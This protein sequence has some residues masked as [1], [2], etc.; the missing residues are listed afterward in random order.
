MYIYIHSLIVSS[1]QIV[2][3]NLSTQQTYWHGQGG[4]LDGHRDSGP[5][6]IQMPGNLENGYS[7][8]R[9]GW[10]VSW[11]IHSNLDEYG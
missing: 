10:M 8:L 5:S 2:R 6:E 1:F 4:G 11:K 9:A 3:H 7:T